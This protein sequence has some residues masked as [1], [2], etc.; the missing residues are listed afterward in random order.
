ML[1][2]YKVKSERIRVS[3]LTSGVNNSEFRTES[4]K[5]FSGFNSQL[6]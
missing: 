4:L 5:L 1:H 3:E 6:Q 2:F